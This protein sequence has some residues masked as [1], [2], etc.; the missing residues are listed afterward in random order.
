MTTATHNHE[1]APMVTSPAISTL[2]TALVGC[3]VGKPRFC[4]CLVKPPI[5]PELGFFFLNLQ[6][7][8]QVFVTLRG[9]GLSHSTSSWVPSARANNPAI[10]GG[11]MCTE[12]LHQEPSGLWHQGTCKRNAVLELIIP[13]KRMALKLFTHFVRKTGVNI[14]SVQ[15]CKHYK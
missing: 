6:W 2:R 12:H 10:W 13:S 15:K 5:F 9:P 11:W 8:L 7:P 4:V 14:L 3:W 1:P